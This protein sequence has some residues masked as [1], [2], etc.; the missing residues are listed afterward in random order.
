MINICE[1][2]HKLAYKNNTYYIGGTMS[3]MIVCH[4]GIRISEILIKFDLMSC[5]LKCIS[6]WSRSTNLIIRHSCLPMLMQTPETLQ[7]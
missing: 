2:R 6:L 4:K 1:K 3:G 5:R 7:W